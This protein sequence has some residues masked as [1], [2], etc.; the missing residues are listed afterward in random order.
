MKASYDVVIVGGAV[1][2]S[3]VAY[4]LAENT[5][6]DGSILVVERDSSYTFSS[7]ALSTSAIRQQYS[8]PINVKI[9]QFGVEFIEGF[10]E[11]MQKFY[12]GEKSPD[13]GFK[14]HGY[15]YCYSPEGVEPAKERV[16]LQRSLGAHTEF[17]APG[18]LKA[19]FPWLNV[20]DLGGGSWGARKEGWF[21]SMGMMG[22]FKRG[23][24]AMGVEYIDNEVQG[25]TI[26]G[27]KVSGV[28]L[29]T[30]GVIAC[31]LLVNAAGPRAN[32]IANMA[33]LN[34]PVE[35]RKRHSFVFSSMTP[36]P[37]RMP[38]VIDMN[39]TFVRPE[40]QLFLT[41]N[42]P[43]PDGPADYDDF[44]T[45]HDEFD[46]YIWP[47][48]YNRIP[49]FDALK[50]QQFWTGHYAYNTL[51]HNAIM[52]FHP[53][54]TNFM[55]ANGFSGHG[56]QQSP[57]VGRGVSELIVSGEYQTLDLS[58]LSYGRVERNEPFME[59]AVI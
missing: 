43:T 59:D 27:D 39:G 5:G 2:G 23:A 55:F 4:W 47:T 24:R 48:L 3:S 36:I 22:G 21:D 8:N 14:E 11:R 31:G 56:L 15:L 41:G 33:G 44:E 49:Q 57:A 29:A 38:N 12:P 13:L 52:G 10:R 40:N 51:D 54:V 53:R 1:I 50:V 7:T 35:P 46:D 30:G 45:K 58:P 42:T 19:K 9:S 34:I 16:E 26:T 25:V 28:K 6:F 18:A 17:L 32:K 37:G 20:D